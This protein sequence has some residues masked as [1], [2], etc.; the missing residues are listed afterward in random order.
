[1]ATRR[2]I[3]PDAIE[4]VIRESGLPVQ[5]LGR[6]TKV[7]HR[8]T[9]NTCCREYYVHEKWLKEHQYPRIDCNRCRNTR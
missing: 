2:P 9:C 5:Y 3:E 8:M 4:W 7:L 1:M 6:Y